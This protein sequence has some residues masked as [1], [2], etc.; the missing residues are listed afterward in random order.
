MASSLPI[1]KLKRS[2]YASCS[3]KM[4]QYLLVH[5]YWSYVEGANV[6][7][8]DS[9]HKDFPIWEQAASRVMYC[10]AS[11][12]HDEMVDYIRDAKMMKEAWENLKKIFSASTTAQKLQL[13]QELN[14]VR[15]KDML[16]TDYTTKIK[17]ICDALGSINVTVDEDEMLQ[18]CLG[19][20]AQRYGPIQ[21][22]ICTQEKPLSFFDLQSMLMVEENHASGLRTVERQA[23]HRPDRLGPISQA[24]CGNRYA[25]R[26]V[27]RPVRCRN[28]ETVG[29]IFRKEYIWELV[30]G[31]INEHRST[32]NTS[33]SPKRTCI[34]VF[35]EHTRC[36]D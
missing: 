5:D 36:I 10:P 11:C 8:P 31:L 28:R 16:V 9:T 23:Q 6:V 33:V 14:N 7:A 20:L 2:N 1:E 3:Y 24:E 4:H 18:I 25:D 35:I 13:W 21:T 15:Q 34:K 29:K 19:G 32:I 27:G 26:C 12:V 30:Q 22:A 17:E